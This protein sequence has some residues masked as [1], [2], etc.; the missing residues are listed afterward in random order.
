MCSPT[1]RKAGTWR[2][3]LSRTTRN[4][5]TGLRSLL[6]SSSFPFSPLYSRGGLLSLGLAW[7][8][9]AKSLQ[10]AEPLSLSL[11]RDTPTFLVAHNKRIKVNHTSIRMKIFFVAFSTLLELKKKKIWSES[12]LY[13]F[14]V[15]LIQFVILECFLT[16]LLPPLDY[17]QN[18]WH[19]LLLFVHNVSAIA[20]NQWFSNIYISYYFFLYDILDYYTYLLNK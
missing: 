9:P 10:P 19:P 18:I 1:T 4:I 14:L 15:I 2:C 7:C 3:I 5:V 12:G 6:L 11:K 17:F 8:I 20:S 13:V 16:L